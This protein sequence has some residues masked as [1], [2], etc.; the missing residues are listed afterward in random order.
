MAPS[1]DIVGNVSD[2]L[3]ETAVSAVQ[4]VSDF[5]QN[6]APHGAAGFASSLPYADIAAVIILALVAGA[7]LGYVMRGRRRIR[8]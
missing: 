5:V 4:N 2:A 1:P 8:I 6:T 3:R 7:C